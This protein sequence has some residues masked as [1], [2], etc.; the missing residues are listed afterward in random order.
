M[1]RGWREARRLTR[2]EALVRTLTS[3]LTAL[4]VSTVLVSSSAG[5]ASADVG[6]WSTP[7]DLSTT[8]GNAYS[9]QLVTDDV[10]PL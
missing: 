10:P 2:S 6:S 3:S 9:P 7:I 1:R 8:G 4:V 5:V